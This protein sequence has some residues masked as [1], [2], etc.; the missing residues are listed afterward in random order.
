MSGKEKGKRLGGP[1]GSTPEKQKKKKEE[2]LDGGADSAIDS[3]RGSRDGVLV[4]ASP[5]QWFKDFDA[6]LS[7]QIEG[8]TTDLNGMKDMIDKARMEAQDARRAAEEAQE[9]MEEV[10]MDVEGIRNDLEEMYLTKKEIEDKLQAM[11][12]DGI[13]KALKDK[14]DQQAQQPQ[15]PHDDR[16][17]QVIVGGLTDEED[18]DRIVKQ[19]SDV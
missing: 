17:L 14:D 4:A 8:I 16:E 13:E 5:P 6:R 18:E 1:T 12:E 10:E 11:V 2:E 9:K 15:H 7:K 3:A 19:I